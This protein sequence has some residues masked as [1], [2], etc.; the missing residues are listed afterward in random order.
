MGYA[1]F[2]QTVWSQHKSCGAVQ[3]H[4]GSDHA[5]A[6]A[7]TRSHNSQRYPRRLQLAQPAGRGAF[8]CVP[9]G[10]GLHLGPC[11]QRGLEQTLRPNE[12]PSVHPLSRRLEDD[13]RER[14]RAICRGWLSVRRGLERGR[15]SA[16]TAQLTFTLHPRSNS[17]PPSSNALE[18]VYASRLPPDIFPLATLTGKN[19]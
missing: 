9:Q 17:V 5:P 2:P 7:R 14:A 13:P 11:Q 1:A 10:R 19:S 15:S 18:S 12:P 4:A 16:A 6:P 3:F 8:A